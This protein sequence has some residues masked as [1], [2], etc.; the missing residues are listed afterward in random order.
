M[1]VMQWL[2]KSIGRYS[3]WLAVDSEMGEHFEG[4]NPVFRV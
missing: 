4:G 2:P 3:E 1:T